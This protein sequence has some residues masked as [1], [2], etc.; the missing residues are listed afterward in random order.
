MKMRFIWYCFNTIVQLTTKFACVRACVCV[1]IRTN[2][3]FQCLQTVV[4]RGKSVKL[5]TY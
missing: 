3:R 1:K 4:A 5:Y 2:E